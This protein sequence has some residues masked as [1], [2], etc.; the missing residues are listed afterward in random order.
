LPFT[1]A[2]TPQAQ[3]NR[4]RDGDSGTVEA[5]LDFIEVATLSRRRA[6]INQVEIDD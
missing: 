5:L 3:G 2:W 4:A 6:H 1:I